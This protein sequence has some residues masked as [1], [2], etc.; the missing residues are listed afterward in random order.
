MQISSEM[1]KNSVIRDRPVKCVFCKEPLFY[2]RDPRY[3][4]E[5]TIDYGQNNHN[6]PY[7]VYAHVRCSKHIFPLEE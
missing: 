7:R 1:L 2:R 6:L 3:E 5:I 4:D